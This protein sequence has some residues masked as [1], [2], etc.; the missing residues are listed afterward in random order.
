[1]FAT[2]QVQDQ[3]ELYL[4][5]FQKHGEKERREGQMEGEKG[6]EGERTQGAPGVILAL[7]CS[8]GTRGTT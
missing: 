1:M 6:R 8:A 5:L 3:F 7:V 4:T 2:Q